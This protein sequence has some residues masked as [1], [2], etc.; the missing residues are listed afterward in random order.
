[1]IFIQF[2]LPL[3]LFPNML[4][5]LK[6]KLKVKCGLHFGLKLSATPAQNG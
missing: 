5:G 4:F 3:S 2:F 1:M 6:K